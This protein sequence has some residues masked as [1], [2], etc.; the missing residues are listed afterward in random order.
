MLEEFH[1]KVL[2]HVAGKENNAAD[3]LSQLGMAE[4][5]DDELEW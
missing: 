4:N 2:H 3:A 1:P 5:P